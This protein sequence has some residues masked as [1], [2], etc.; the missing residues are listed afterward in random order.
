MSV[1]EMVATIALVC[2]KYPGLERGLS[3]FSVTLRF[4]WYRLSRAVK[5]G[6]TRSMP[7][8]E[9]MRPKVLESLSSS[10][11]HIT[12]VMTCYHSPED[13]LA[14]RNDL[15]KGG[16]PRPRARGAGPSKRGAPPLKSQLPTPNYNNSNHGGRVL[17][18][19]DRKYLAPFCAEAAG[20][21]PTAY[22]QIVRHTCA[23]SWLEGSSS[24]V[25][26]DSW[27]LH[28]PSLWQRSYIPQKHISY[29]YYV[30]MASN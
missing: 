13:N 6:Y 11:G 3:H 9:M 20:L 5:V 23:S 15:K 25:N 29:W 26:H 28:S 21:R 1:F 12:D 22:V 8:S 27:P 18:D 10:S 7:L 17:K 2:P 4:P 14:M 16:T 19:R 30:P 24:C